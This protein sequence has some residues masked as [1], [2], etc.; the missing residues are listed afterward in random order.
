MKGETKMKGMEKFEEWLKEKDL[1]TSFESFNIKN[2]DILINYGMIYCGKDVSF[3][4]LPK[5]AQIGYFMAYIMEIT[6][7]KDSIEQIYAEGI[8]AVM[9][10]NK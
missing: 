3:F 5:Q 1:I 10:G 2:N 4:D 9:E 8:K 7:D 6:N